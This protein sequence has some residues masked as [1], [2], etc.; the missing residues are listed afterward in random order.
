MSQSAETRPLNTYIFFADG[1][2]T[3]TSQGQV[4]NNGTL[5]SDGLHSWKVQCRVLSSGGGYDLG[6][7][8]PTHPATHFNTTSGTSWGLRNN[9]EQYPSTAQSG[10]NFKEGDVLAFTLD[11]TQKTL[12]ISINEGPSLTIPNVI[13]PVHVAFCGGKGAQAHI[14]TGKSSK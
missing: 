10:F 4:V 11:C 9:G 8:S 3:A 2:Q 13:L 7:V 12:S 14:L 5:F 1:T 6:V